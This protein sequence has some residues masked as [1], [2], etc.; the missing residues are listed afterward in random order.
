MSSLLF[1]PRSI[2][3]ARA[4]VNRGCRLKLPQS[5]LGSPASFGGV[6]TNPFGARM[7][8]QTQASYYSRRAR[9]MLMR[10]APVARQRAVILQS[11]GIAAETKVI[12]TSITCHCQ[13]DGEKECQSS[14]LPHSQEDS[15]L[16]LGL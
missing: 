16:F 10:Q 11:G 13:A 1:D 3:L 2:P 14:V 12:F 15:L 4:P 6:M 5:L 7:R 8:L 9:R